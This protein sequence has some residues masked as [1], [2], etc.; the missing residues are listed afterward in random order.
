[1]WDGPGES[2]PHLLGAGSRHRTYDLVGVG[3]D[4]VHA[5]I[6]IDVFARDP[7][8]LVTNGLS[9]YVHG[10]LLPGWPWVTEYG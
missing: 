4:H 2:V 8:L 7:H 10:T 9:L 5:L 3:I 6:G 1:M